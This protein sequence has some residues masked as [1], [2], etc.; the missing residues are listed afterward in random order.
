MHFWLRLHGPGRQP[1]EPFL[2]Q[3][4]FEARPIIW[5]F[6]PLIGFYDYLEPTLWLK[7]QTLGKNSS[8]TNSNLY[9]FG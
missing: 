2:A 8:S 6:K 9:H 7:N 1:N 4:F 5:V 3:G